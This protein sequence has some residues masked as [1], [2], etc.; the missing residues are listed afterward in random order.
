MALTKTTKTAKDAANTPAQFQIGLVDESGVGAGPFP[1]YVYV[2]EPIS[3]ALVTPAQEGADAAGVVAPAGAVGIRGW[4]SGI[5]SKLSAALAVTQSGTWTVQP[6][7][8]ANITPWLVD[9]VAS[10]TGG[11]STYSAIGGTGAALLTNTVVSVK[12]SG[13]ASLFGISFVNSGVSAAYVQ[14]FDA[15]PGSVVLGTT[16]P[17]LAFWVPAGGAWEEKWADLGVSF[18]TAISVAATSTA[19]G[20]AAPAAGVFAAL[21]YK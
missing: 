21:Y 5:Y 20:S 3:G 10:P 1:S 6:G 2:A 11:V 9:S 17:K 7:N 14:I 13:P 12:A 18:S 19:T 15:A 8:A 16:A 4:L